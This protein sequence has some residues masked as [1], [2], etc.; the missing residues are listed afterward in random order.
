MDRGS[1][2][3]FKFGDGDKVFIQAKGC[4]GT[5]A[6]GQGKCGTCTAAAHGT[7]RKLQANVS[8][9]RDV[10]L[11]PGSGEMYVP[12][13]ELRVSPFDPNALHLNM[14]TSTGIRAPQ[15]TVQQP[16]KV[17]TKAIEISSEMTL[18]V[19]ASWAVENKSALEASLR[20]T[21]NLG[22][23]ESLV[24][25]KISAARR[26][27]EKRQ[28][29][30]AGRVKVE[31]T[32]GTNSADSASFVSSNVQALSQGNSAALQTF[33]QQLDVSLREQGKAPINM[34]P[35]AVT[36]RPP[37]RQGATFAA[38]PAGSVA[39]QFAPVNT[40]QQQ[41]TQDSTSESKSSTSNMLVIVGIAILAPSCLRPPAVT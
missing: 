6:D 25:T 7:L 26:L 39:W 14:P 37:T 8:P 3:K 27:T 38:A 5:A 23:D 10:D 18:P 19:T 29:Q 40:A 16:T 4:A 2:R 31:F 22:V 36:F 13:V 21:L 30:A 41:T 34:L 20:K 9:K 17:T 1:F 15:P 28:L 12:P 32:I 11:S 33:T 35:A 24:I